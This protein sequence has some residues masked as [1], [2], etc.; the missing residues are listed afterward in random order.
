MAGKEM[1]TD[2][3][4]DQTKR[5]K[6]TLSN[7]NNIL[8]KCLNTET[9]KLDSCLKHFSLLFKKEDKGLLLNEVQDFRPRLHT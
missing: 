3:L 7:S 8:R 2:E 6:K 9:L 4:F 5:Y 1:G